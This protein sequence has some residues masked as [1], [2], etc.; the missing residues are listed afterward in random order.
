[1]ILLIVHIIAFYPLFTKL[2]GKNNFF[3]NAT[4]SY[5]LGIFITSYM[6]FA[7]F[8]FV[9]KFDPQIYIATLLCI[10]VTTYFKY[11]K[12][13]QNPLKLMISEIKEISSWSIT[14]KLLLTPIII[15]FIFTMLSGLYW[16]V[17]DWDALTLY[18]FRGLVISREGSIQRLIDQDAN[19]YFSYPLFTSIIHAITYQ[20][21]FTSPM[22]FY[23][24][25]FISFS[26]VFYTYAR[27]Y[28]TKEFSLILTLMF[29]TS[30]QFLDHSRM[31]YTNMPY[32]LYLCLFFI[33]FMEW[34][35]KQQDSQLVLAFLSLCAAIWT[36]NSEPFWIISIPL[37]I[38][39]STRKN[40]VKICLVVILLLIFRLPWENF[41]H[42]IL[43]T[44]SYVSTT[45]P[46]QEG[47]KLITPAYL[48]KLAG[49]IFQYFI[50]PYAFIH[51]GF[52]STV[53]YKI[54]TKPSKDE[55]LHIIGISLLYMLTIAGTFYLSLTYPK[56]IRVGGSLERMSM[57]FI[58]T[59]LYFVAHSKIL[60]T[61]KHSK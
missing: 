18:D 47:L 15:V 45:I 14:S 52:A 54:L 4:L 37:L 12:L 22:F 44:T 25:F 2:T 53:I 49:Y 24:L 38:L 28:N 5:L 56:W 7:S 33:F 58:P 20:I 59:I 51:I 8:L 3:L 39:M 48:I 13:I 40:F 31:A 16:P 32:A 57:L 21:D 26:I 9:H 46:L 17:R 27:K 55:I 41:Q 10:I 35:N 30:S 60:N 29:V 36:R 61:R 34:I 50:Q 19:Y 11:W 43:T 42:H 1:M 23:S 6:Y